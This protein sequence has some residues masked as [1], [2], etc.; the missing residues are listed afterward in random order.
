MPA[1]SNRIR[2]LDALRALAVVLVLGC[3]VTAAPPQAGPFFFALSNHW[4]RGGWVGVDL[5][6]VLSGFLI[7]GLLFREH[8]RSGGI[9]FGR[10]FIRRGFKIY[11]AFYFFIFATIV[12][13]LRPPATSWREI[14]NELF[15]LQNYD[16]GLW[17]HTW[18]LAVEEHFYLLLAF[19]LFFLIRS[20]KTAGSFRSIPRKFFWISVFCFLLRLYAILRIQP[21]GYFTHFFPTHFRIDALFFGVL[22]SYF[23][24]YERA[25]YDALQKRFGRFFPFLGPALLLPA[26]LVPLPG[27]VFI[28][29]AGL[30]LFYLGSGLLLMAFLENEEAFGGN[31]ARLASYIGTRSYSIYIWHV[32]AIHLCDP[33]LKFSGNWQLYWLSCFV[34]PVAVGIVMAELIEYPVLRIRDKFF[35]A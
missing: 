16:W 8:R 25:R 6:F 24:H 9:R 14:F 4:R 21:Y 27:N 35:P 12:F 11:P 30:T 26:F 17:G 29:T 7:S 10:F 32:Y 31:A 2:S 19:F 1:H 20:G 13:Q 15:F 18:S 22:I 34:L 33:V 23:Y 3:H 28:S 5:F